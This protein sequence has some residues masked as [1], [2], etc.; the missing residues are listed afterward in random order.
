LGA[1]LT[2][3]V[4]LTGCKVPG[5]GAYSGAT[6]QAQDT[7]KLWQGFFLAGLVVGGL[8]FLL[9][10]FAILRYRKR[11]EAIP[12]QTQYHTLIE[13]LYTALPIIIVLVLFG[14][15]VVTENRVTA[16]SSSPAVRVKVIAFQWGWEFDYPGQH[17]KPIIGAANLVDGKPVNVPEMVVPAGQTV[18]IHLVS[19]DVI[20]GFYVPE[21]NFSRYAQPGFGDSPDCD[22]PHPSNPGSCQLFD[23]NVTH[24][25][26][27]RGQCTQLCGLYH[28]VMLFNVKAV[29]PA[30]YRAWI[31]AH[32]TTSSSSS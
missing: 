7:F 4:L 3:G 24:T 1:A 28:S 19:K 9:I 2:A 15:T 16:I 5:F 27:F 26:T 22:L 18:Q 14:F 25:G 20:H 6:T 10:L 21:F 8:V 32:Q 23:L 17:I 13:I 29:T 11:T 31:S 12:K 30:Q